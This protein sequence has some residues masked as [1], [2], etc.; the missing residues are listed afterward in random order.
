MVSDAYPT[1]IL[2][3][4]THFTSWQKCPDSI[5]NL[6]STYHFFFSLNSVEKCW[7]GRVALKVPSPLFCPVNDCMLMS[8]TY[9]TGLIRS[10]CCTSQKTQPP[11]HVPRFTHT[12]GRMDLSAPPTITLPYLHRSNRSTQNHY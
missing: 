8:N 9:N 10:T 11:S 1:H 4:N 2:R 7:D 3:S 5:C 12:H 6:F